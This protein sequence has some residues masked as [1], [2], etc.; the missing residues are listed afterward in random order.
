[1]NKTAAHTNNVSFLRST[2]E[3]IDESEASE[4]LKRREISTRN[5]SSIGSCHRFYQP[6]LLHILSYV[7]FCGLPNCFRN[8]K[9][10]SRMPIPSGQVHRKRVYPLVCKE[11]KRRPV[12]IFSLRRRSKLYRSAP[13]AFYHESNASQGTDH[14]IVQ[15]ER[16]GWPLAVTRR[17]C[18]P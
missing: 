1:M 6:L 7:K 2:H 17:P 3:H 5:A 18:I 12:K 4:F 16:S 11:P 13:V 14:L 15:M 9:C 8:S 10:P